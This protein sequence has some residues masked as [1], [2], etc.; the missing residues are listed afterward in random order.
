MYFNRV[1]GFW[2][3]D[4]SMLR[5]LLVILINYSNALL[6]EDINSI[7]INFTRASR[8]SCS[9]GIPR[10]QRFLIYY[11]NS[12]CLRLIKSHTTF[13]YKCHE[14][15]CIF[16]WCT[17]KCYN[18]ILC[19][20]SRVT[21]LTDRCLCNSCISLWRHMSQRKLRIGRDSYCCVLECQRYFGLL[22]SKV[23]QLRT[24]Y[25]HCCL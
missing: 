3:S 20:C 7:Y 5:F 1:T 21:H 17:T 25:Y 16:T 22:R 4:I 12:Y 11:F 8:S 15:D 23:N 9:R 18:N 6:Y 14:I 24:K 19:W 10:G 13:L 2:L